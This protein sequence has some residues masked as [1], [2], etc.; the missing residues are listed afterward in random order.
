MWRQTTILAATFLAA[1]ALAPACGGPAS[2]PTVGAEAEVDETEESVAEVEEAMPNQLTQAEIDGG[3]KLL[4]DGE[5]PDGWTGYRKETFP[6]G[7]Q[8]LAC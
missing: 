7:W 2:E 1:V 8:S 6:K 4:F 5:K 3:W